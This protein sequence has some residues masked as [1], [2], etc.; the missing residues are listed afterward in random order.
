MRKNFAKLLQHRFCKESVAFTFCTCCD[1]VTGDLVS[2]V[3]VF[4]PLSLDVRA[5]TKFFEVEQKEEGCEKQVFQFCVIHSNSGHNT[6][7]GGLCLILSFFVMKEFC[8]PCSCRRLA[9]IF[10]VG[11][12][13]CL[14]FIGLVFCPYL[15]TLEGVCNCIRA[16]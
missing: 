10:V 1:L 4:T 8:R 6:S 14:A 9:R 12:K 15:P 11:L 7:S 2:D 13:S 5:A 3:L 16:P